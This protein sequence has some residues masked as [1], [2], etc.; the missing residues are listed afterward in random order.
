MKR[1]NSFAANTESMYFLESYLLDLEA[2][3]YTPIGVTAKYDI[4]EKMRL[5][6]DTL[7]ANSKD[8]FDFYK[9]ELKEN[10]WAALEASWTLWNPTPNKR[11]GEWGGPNKMTFYLDKLSP[12]Y[13]DCNQLGF[14]QCTYD[15]HGSPGFE[16]VTYRGSVV[17]ISDLYDSLSV[18]NI[19]KRG[20]GKNSLQELAQ[21]RM[22]LK[23]DEELRLWAQ[24][25]ALEYDPYVIFYKWRDDLNLV[26]HEDTN[27]RTMRLVF[28]PA[29]QAF[30]HRG[31]VA[32]ATNIKIHFSDC[33]KI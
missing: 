11:Y 9:R 22:G 20:G 7:Y 23:L 1:E 13:E 27:C 29:H 31:G 19:S 6:L 21:H 12:Y 24:E 18:A 4:L 17:D 16:S 2:Q 15:E 10:T 32:N 28:R 26:P 8:L 3:L 33:D 5:N 14:G 30:T 25:R